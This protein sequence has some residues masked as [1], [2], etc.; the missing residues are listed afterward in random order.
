MSKPNTPHTIVISIIAVIT[1]L[2]ILTLLLFPPNQTTMPKV[3][4]VKSHEGITPFELIYKQEVR[5]QHD[6]LR[7]YYNH[8]DNTTIWTLR[9]AGYGESS[10]FVM[11]GKV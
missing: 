10:I 5:G 4:A 1:S 9:M 8:N 11:K 2:L 6:V 7:K 3:E